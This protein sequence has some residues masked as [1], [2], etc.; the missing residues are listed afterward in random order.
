MG[1]SCSVSKAKDD[2]RIPGLGCNFN[3]E[4][5]EGKRLS[6]KVA[7]ARHKLTGAVR[8][9][10]RLSKELHAC[11]DGRQLAARIRA[12]KGF[13]HPSAAQ[14]YEA[15]AAGS[16]TNLVY[17]KLGG[18]KV[19]D[20]MSKQKSISESQVAGTLQQV[21]QAL[22]A[23]QQHGLAHGHLSPKNVFVN[24]AGSAS[25]TDLGLA[26]YF[27]PLPARHCNLEDMQYVAPEVAKQWLA[28]QANRKPSKLS[29]DQAE[30]D[31]LDRD[32]RTSLLTKETVTSCA[33]VW[34]CGML[35]F[36]LLTGKSPYDYFKASDQVL[37]AE[38]ISKFR[39]PQGVSLS[40]GARGLLQKMLKLNPAER[41]SLDDILEDPWLNQTS[42]EKQHP[43]PRDVCAELATVHSET[44]VKKLMMRVVASRI[45]ARKLGKLRLAFNTADLNNDGQISLAEF[46]AALMEYP[47]LAT[48]VEAAFKDIDYHTSGFISLDEFI[49][50]TVDTQRQ[51]VEACL[52]DAFRAIDKD[53]DDAL[54]LTEIEQAIRSMGS[55]GADTLVDLLREEVSG[56]LTFMQFKDLVLREGGRSER[57]KLVEKEGVSCCGR[58]ARGCRVLIHAEDRNIAAMVEQE[59]ISSEKGS[60]ALS[61]RTSGGPAT[62]S[63][64]S[65]PGRRASKASKASSSSPPSSPGRAGKRANLR[66]KEACRQFVSIRG[67]IRNQEFDQD[68]VQTLSKY[69]NVLPPIRHGELPQVGESPNGIAARQEAVSETTGVQKSTPEIAN[70]TRSG[71][72]K[73]GKFTSNTGRGVIAKAVPRSFSTGSD[74]KS[75]SGGKAFEITGRKSRL[76][77]G[78]FS[79]GQ[80]RKTISATL[81]R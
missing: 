40:S 64:F 16:F 13:E 38:S 57:V 34:S 36:L 58:V 22:Q 52:H 72:L 26:G 54:T 61:G 73:A 48:D 12:L 74:G 1:Q 80:G 75:E 50:A 70:K 33:D 8:V 4:Y 44:H 65:S 24:S 2:C 42:A 21:L 7:D 11:K 71:S 29:A 46:K 62:A 27:K 20:D 45:P 76:A 77:A 60:S 25:I 55:E 30:A 23:G 47:E 41:P 17:Q 14:F 49:A 10:Y 43:L 78:K 81:K 63:P 6:A 31:K 67:T 66:S 69:E 5:I 53:G 51:L 59:K 39:L 18:R 32:L 3:D 9:V 28:E 19:L 37:L 15:Y 68:R 35:L 56:P 79:S